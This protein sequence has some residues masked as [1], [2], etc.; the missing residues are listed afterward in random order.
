[1]KIEEYK[2][3]FSKEYIEMLEMYKELRE[4]RGI[5]RRTVAINLGMD[6]RTYYKKETYGI[7]ISLEEMQ[8]FLRVIGFEMGIVSSNVFSLNKKQNNEIRFS[9]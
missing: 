6:Y 2:K 5:K 8:N 3:R 9:K 1:M 7:A 4:Q